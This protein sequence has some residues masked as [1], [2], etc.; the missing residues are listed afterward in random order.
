MH[1][2][3]KRMLA[4]LEKKKKASRRKKTSSGKWSL[5]ILKCG[6]GSF[7]TGITNDLERRFKMHQAGKASRYTRSHG[8]VEMLYSEKC[9][10]RSSALIRECEVKEWPRTRKEKL[11]KSRDGKRGT[12]CKAEGAARA[13]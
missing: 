13:A 10:D 11:I 5:Y 6:D 3:Y 7:Y 12:F 2:T 4:G 9:G 8:P 1:P